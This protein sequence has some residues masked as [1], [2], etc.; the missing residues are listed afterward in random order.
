MR[1]VSKEQFHASVG[2]MDVCLR[3]ERDA[4]Y[5]ETRGRHLMGKTTPGYIGVGPRGYF[6]SDDV[7][8]P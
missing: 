8:I 4:T 6:V 7:V 5:W 2:Q 3:C 1:E